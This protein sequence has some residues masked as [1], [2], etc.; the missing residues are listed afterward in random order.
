MVRQQAFLPTLAASIILMVI[1]WR[2]IRSSR[3]VI[4]FWPGL[5]AACALFSVTLA[6]GL[7]GLGLELRLVAVWLGM[8]G[9]AVVCGLGM[10]LAGS[11]LCEALA[12]SC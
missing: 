3:L 9:L 2:Q 4:T 6:L 12:G 10:V 1:G 5:A 7:S 11:I 8:S